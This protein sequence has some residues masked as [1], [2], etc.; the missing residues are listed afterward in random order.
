MLCGWKSS[1]F[2][3]FHKESRQ[4]PLLFA[5]FSLK[6]SLSKTLVQFSFPGLLIQ[7]HFFKF[8]QQGCHRILKTFFLFSIK[9]S[10]IKVQIF[11]RKFCQKFMNV[12]FQFINTQQLFV[13]PMVA[14]GHFSVKSKQTNSANTLQK[15]SFCVSLADHLMKT[16][17]AASDWH[18][19]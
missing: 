13:R 8:W 6:T 5:M 16:V 19:R 11:C 3:P 17:R 1:F 12:N 15:S 7:D 4:Q 14:S 10:S 2:W 18:C 9:K